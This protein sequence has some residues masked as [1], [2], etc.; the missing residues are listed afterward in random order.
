[1]P[2]PIL[3]DE[4]SMHLHSKFSPGTQRHVRF[5][6][7]HLPNAAKSLHKAL[8]PLD[9]FP[10]FT[11]RKTRGLNNP[12][13]SRNLAQFLISPHSIFFIDTIAGEV[14]CR[15]RDVDSQRHSGEVYV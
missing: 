4:M 12:L 11:G 8:R 7:T 5:T 15:G 1:M 9:V 2:R 3:S 6:C 10:I 13:D 14:M